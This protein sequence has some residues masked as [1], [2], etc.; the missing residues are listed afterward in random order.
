MQHRALHDTRYHTS[1]FQP[2]KRRHGKGISEIGMGLAVC[3]EIV[4]RHGGELWVES[5]IGE[6]GTFFFTLPK[7]TAGLNASNANS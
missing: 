7:L 4:E 3:K 6:R 2:L 5:E 1:I